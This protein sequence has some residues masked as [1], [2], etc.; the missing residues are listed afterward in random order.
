MKT[1]KNEMKLALGALTF[2][3]WITA[4]AAAPIVANM[5]VL[6]ATPQFSIQSA[7]GITNQIQFSTN[8]GPANWTVLTNIV[9]TQSPYL[10][11]DLSAP[12]KPSRFYRVAAL[13]QTN[14]PTPA[15]MVL[16]PAGNFT[17][18][19]AFVEG[20]GDDL[21]LHSVSLSAFYMDRYEITEALWDEV[22]NWAVSNGYSFDNTGSGKATTHPVQTVSWYDCVKW[23]NARSEKEGRVPAYYT[24]AEHTAVYRGGQTDLQ[25]DWVNWAAGYQLPTEAQWEKAARG[26]LSGHRFPWADVEEI[27]HSRANYSSST[28]YAYDT[29]P[30]R[31]YHPTFAVGNFPYTSPA[32]YFAPNGQGLYDMM[33]NV[34]EWCWDWYDAN[35]YL[36]GTATDPRGPTS[37]SFRVDRGGRW[38][39]NAFLGRTAFRD[40]Y[41]PTFS[42]NVMGFRSVLPA[43]Q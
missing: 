42:D 19:D 29:S 5:K 18:G 35:A 8:L 24:N 31:G 4:Q 33:G 37:G 34:S 22:Y 43:G 1:L 40:Y 39:R 28:D 13:N 12:P 20:F 6:G 32:G 10:F 11:V 26:G 15:G 41:S 25:N 38:D 36:S 9:V 27:T 7:L 30:T 3:V 23:C 14:D 2:G 21:P 16:I 17:M